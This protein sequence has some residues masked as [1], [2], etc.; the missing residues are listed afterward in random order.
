MTLQPIDYCCDDLA[1]SG[2]LADGSGGKPAPGILVAH[3]GPGLVDHPKQRTESL[4]ELGYVALAVDLF[5]EKEPSL[6]R[7]RELTGMLLAD[8]MELR[9]R[10]RVAFDTLREQPNVD[11]NHMGAIGF[12]LGGAATLELARSGAEI[13]ATIGFHANLITTFPAESG[14]I[15]GKVLVCMGADD[16]IIGQDQRDAFA[17]EMTAAGA[18]WQMHLYGGTGHSFTN[19]DIDAYGYE[20]F[21]YDERADRRSWQAMRDLF[22]EAFA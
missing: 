21:A 10:M 1:L 4:A 18:D 2:F 19:R 8:R 22:D 5:G 13:A 6:D 14:A 20:G 15:Q 11:P 17:D 16:P 7:A 12:C 3:E 9:K